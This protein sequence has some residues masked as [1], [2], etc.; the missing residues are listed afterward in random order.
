MMAHQSVANTKGSHWAVY[1]YLHMKESVLT[2]HVTRTCDTLQE[3]RHCK[4]CVFVCVSVTEQVNTD[5][6]IASLLTNIPISMCAG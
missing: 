3:Q 1:E 5:F 2:G 6:C 4:V